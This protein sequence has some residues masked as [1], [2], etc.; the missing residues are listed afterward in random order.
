MR[1]KGNIFKTNIFFILIVF[2]FLGCST[3]S[4]TLNSSPNEAKVSISGIN[5]QDQKNVGQTPLQ[6]DFEEI[7]QTIG[8]FK[9][10]MFYIKKE[11]FQTEKVL[12]PPLTSETISMNL[13]LKRE[14]GLEDQEKI[15]FVM[16]HLFE[17]QQLI[18]SK[19]FDEAKRV[20]N[21]VKERAPYVSATYEIEGG[22]LFIQEKYQSA[23]DAYRKA[24]K[25]NPENPK[26]AK[27]KELIKEKIN[28]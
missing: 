18:W 12:L 10:V 24:M 27:M 20:I 8:S 11:G 23:L 2:L 16:D 9:P 14:I 22:L 5:E 25:Y 3:G 4:I 26:L 7:Y 21:Q 19:R 1:Q 15:N 6:I 13:E 17:A 28:R